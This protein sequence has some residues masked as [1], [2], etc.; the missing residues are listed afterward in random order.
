MHNEVHVCTTPNG[1]VNSVDCWCE[2]VSISRVRNKH[3]IDCLIV[4]HCDDTLAH[5]S[6]VVHYR[7]MELDT[8]DYF[9]AGLDSPWISRSLHPFGN[10][11][12][13]P[14]HDDPNERSL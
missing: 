14:P 7:N 4:E 9:G 13:L 10:P 5:R 2:P 12:T 8:P 3:G 1:H 11:P 6:L